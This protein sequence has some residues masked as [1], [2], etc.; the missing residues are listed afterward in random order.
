MPKVD[1]GLV[2]K[3]RWST[4]GYHHN[5]DT[6]QYNDDDENNADFPQDL[7]AV[8]KCIAEALGHQRYT[9]NL[10]HRD[11]YYLELSPPTI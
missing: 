9:Y 3:L 4:L 1:E 2:D 10:L 7:A 8:A 6:K 5:W 11:I